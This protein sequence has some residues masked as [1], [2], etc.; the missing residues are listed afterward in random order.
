MPD[1]AW[2]L[3]VL[4]N[5]YIQKKN[6]TETGRRLLE[7][8]IEVK[9]NDSW[10]LNSLAAIE[11]KKGN[12]EQAIELFEQAIK[13]N[14][15]NANPY[16]GKAVAYEMLKKV[17]VAADSLAQLF[18]NAKMQDAR[19]KGLFEMARSMYEQFQ[20]D[21]AKT[22]ESD[23]FKCI[24]SYKTKLEQLSG[25]P[26]RINEEDFEDKVGARIQMAWKHGRDYHLVSTRRGYSPVLLSHLEAH[27]LTHLKLET[28]A[29]NVGKNLYFATSGK[30][31]EA[32]I[33]SIE[34]DVQKLKKKG[35]SE[36]SL[37]NVMQTLVNGLSGFLFNCPID[38]II[39][40]HLRSE[41]PILHP[42]QYL[43]TKVLA[44]EAWQVNSD[45]KVIALTPRKIM[46]ATNALNGANAIFLDV[47][48]GGG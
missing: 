43:S 16:Y 34:S 29:R 33:R 9:P 18:S 35:Y 46:R 3:V 42:A 36:S 2:S 31:R 5:L 28:E 8:A 38:M 27:E 25:Y 37:T 4:A 7:K 40:R 14:P 21:L 48:F 44:T 13:A 15:E 19:S 20:N 10:A 45:P 26:I 47:L 24:Q 22:N 23:A 30:S 32:A 41:F 12:I 1:D 39:E 17:D 6:D 11:L